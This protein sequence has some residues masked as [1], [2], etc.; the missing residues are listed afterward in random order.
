MISLTSIFLAASTAAYPS[1]YLLSKLFIIYSY[2][3]SKS[4]TAFLNFWFLNLKY[5][6]NFE[7]VSNGHV[8]YD[9]N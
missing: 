4:L 2:A 5:W 3:V 1:I 7:N 8:F 9:S 6:V